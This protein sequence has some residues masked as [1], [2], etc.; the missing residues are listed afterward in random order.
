MEV[1]AINKRIEELYPQNP[2]QVSEDELQKKTTY[3]LTKT[4]SENDSKPNLRDKRFKNAYKIYKINIA[5]LLLVPYNISG[6]N[7]CPKA[8]ICKNICL[9][10][11]GSNAGKQFKAQLRRTLSFLRDKKNFI[12]NLVKEIIEFINLCK[13]SNLHPAI[14]LNGY[15]DILW[16]K[17]KIK[18]KDVENLFMKHKHEPGSFRYKTDDESGKYLYEKIKYS[19]DQNKHRRFNPED[20][21][22]IIELFYDIHFYDYTKHTN[23]KVPP[24]YHLTFSYDK[25]ND[26]IVNNMNIAVIVDRNLKNELLNDKKYENI[27]IDGDF[28]DCRILDDMLLNSKRKI[29][30]LEY[31]KKKF[32]NINS[33]SEVAFK[34]EEKEK[35]IDK[36]LK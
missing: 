35:F 15:S 17:E 22:S 1:Q 31:Q 12:K 23:R 13:K 7:L 6:K 28:Q 34:L 29:V 5:E 20:E 16:E 21:I 18:F 3:L 36:F 10:Y 26:E 2:I 24:N 25:Q 11:Q 30:L 32:H 4:I 8:G 9:A 27:L 14:R 19:L 33:D